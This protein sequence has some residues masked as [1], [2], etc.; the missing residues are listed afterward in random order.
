MVYRNGGFERSG[1]NDSPV[2]CQSREMAFPQKSE[3]ISP[4][5]QKSVIQFRITPFLYLLIL[6]FLFNLRF[7]ED[8]TIKIAITARNA[9]ITYEN[10]EILLLLT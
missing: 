5:T 9:I 6:L 10:A 7:T 3:S 2:D 4:F 1:V 8:V